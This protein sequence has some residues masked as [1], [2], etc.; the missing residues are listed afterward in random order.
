MD[1]EVAVLTRPGVS[2]GAAG[3]S[4]WRKLSLDPTLGQRAAAWMRS[5]GME[6]AF[7]PG[8]VVDAHWQHSSLPCWGLALLCRASP[9]DIQR[10]GNTV[11]AEETE[12]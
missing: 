8:A 7:V 11:R 12:M 9:S 3:V 10:R 4:G 5:W 6:S 2:P 1:G